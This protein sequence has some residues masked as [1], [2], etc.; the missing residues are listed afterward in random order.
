MDD[1]WRFVNVC[2]ASFLL[3]CF[4]KGISWNTNN[5]KLLGERNIC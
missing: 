2:Y 4:F 1:P 3:S 5:D